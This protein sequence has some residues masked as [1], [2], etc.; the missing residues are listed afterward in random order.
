MY[1]YDLVLSNGIV[2]DALSQFYGSA[3]VAVRKGKIVRVSAEIDPALS[4]RVIDCQ[5]K[6]VMPGQIDTHAHVAGRTR[7]WDPAIGHAMLAR[8]GTTTVIDM[9]GTGPSLIDGIKRRGAGL[10]VGGMMA[11]IKGSTIPQ[12][13]ISNANITDAIASSLSQGCLGVK[14]L[15]GYQPFSTETT[16]RIIEAANNQAAYVAIHIGTETAGSHIGGLRELPNILSKGRIHVCHINSYCRGVVDDPDLECK[17]ALSIL[18]R[19]S[20]QI[21]SESYNAVQNGTSGSCNRNG[22]ASSDVLR[23]CLKLGNFEPNI[24]GVRSAI[25]EGFASVIS[26]R[27][28]TIVYLNGKEAINLYESAGTNVGLSFPVNLPSS[29]FQLATS[30]TDTGEFIV[31][32]VSTDGG[33][34]PRNIAIQTTAAL[35]KF[36][37]LTP[38]EMVKKLSLNPALMFGLESKGHLSEGADADITVIDPEKCAPVMTIVA[39]EVIMD[40]GEV[41]GIGGTL[42]VTD[43]GE[44]TARETGLPYKVVSLL[45]SKLYYGYS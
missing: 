10:N 30:K 40:N 37:A 26:Q 28:E 20:G 32:A 34:H 15:G 35:V 22:E 29:A 36:G 45:G 7:N 6:W 19:L 23:N 16:T 1:K 4:E 17:E 24:D 11:L 25:K 33:S 38:L 5:H 3:D 2:I 8:A 42:L 12:Y 43:Q 21:N 31:D 39:G 18:S 44:N 14:I 27:D 9:A 41:L 13:S